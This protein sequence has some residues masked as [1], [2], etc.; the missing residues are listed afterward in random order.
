M[1]WCLRLI[2]LNSG[3]GCYNLGSSYETTIQNLAIAVKDI[4][5]SKVTISNNSISANKHY[6]V[7]N[8]RLIE[9]KTGLS[10]KILFKEIVKRYYMWLKILYSF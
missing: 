10:Q 3:S 5:R 7:P 2:S 1:I 8:T 4:T 9:K 6:Y